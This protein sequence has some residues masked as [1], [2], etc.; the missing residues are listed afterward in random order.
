MIYR[1]IARRYA[2]ALIGAAAHR[3][4][5]DQV[6]RE[7]Q[8]AQDR[9]AATDALGQALA[10]PEIPWPRKQALLA[11]AFAGALPLVLAFISLLVQRRRQRYL[12]DVIE[13]YRRMADEMR[14][15]VEAHVAS[16]VPM[17][18]DQQERLRRAL[19]RYSGKRVR[20]RCEVAPDLL[21][22][23]VVRMQ[24][25]VIDASARGRLETLRAALAAARFRGLGG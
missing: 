16:A 1:R 25:T 8:A 7:L 20:L 10:H 6:E 4:I 2:A 9:L 13:E 18:P 21:A 5:V 24:D 15:T 14:A 11:A 19:E 3:G 23:V 17:A 12:G 22:G